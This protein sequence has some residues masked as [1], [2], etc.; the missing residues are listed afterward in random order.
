[1]Q[2][3]EPYLYYMD[4]YFKNVDG[5]YTYVMLVPD[6]GK[7]VTVFERKY[8]INM[9]YYFREKNVFYYRKSVG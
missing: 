8:D 1:M 5:G 6:G 4:S 2:I 3:I 7:N 9:D